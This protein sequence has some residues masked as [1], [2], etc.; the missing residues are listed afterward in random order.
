MWHWIFLN[1]KS[2]FKQA[3]HFIYKQCLAFL[4]FVKKPY[5]GFVPVYGNVKYA[6]H[7]DVDL[8]IMK[9]YYWKQIEL[10]THMCNYVEFIII[11]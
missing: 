9:L 2:S 6:I 7:A 3:S 4:L 1:R 5:P 8:N 11:W 10:I